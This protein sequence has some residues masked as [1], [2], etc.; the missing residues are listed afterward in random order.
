VVFRYFLGTS[1]DWSEEVTRILLIWL[2]YIGAA[3][4]L[5]RKAHIV[6][7]HFLG[8]TSHRTRRYIECLTYALVVA[9]SVFLCIQGIT[10]ALLSMHTTFPALQIPVAWQYFGLPAGAFL[11]SIYGTLHLIDAVRQRE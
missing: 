8:T 10:F 9:F 1:L 7:D 2:T 5:K 6:V 4:A 3:V 11:M